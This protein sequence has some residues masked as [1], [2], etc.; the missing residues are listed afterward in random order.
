VFFSF[1]FTWFA[2]PVWADCEAYRS[3][4]GKSWVDGKCMETPLGERWWPH[5]L[6]GE[7]DQAGSTNWYTKPEIVARALAQV[8]QNRVVKI[9]QEYSSDMPLF[10][11]RQFSLRIPGG[12]T[13]DG[14][15]GNQVVWNDEFLA[16]EVGQVGT[17]FDGL[18][19]VGIQIGKAGDKNQIRFYNG[20]TGSEVQDAY[21]LKK[22]GTEHLHPIVARGVLI[23]VAAARG[24]DVMKAGEVISLADVRTALKKQGMADFELRPGDVVLFRTGWEK[25]W[26]VDNDQ[27]NAGC[28]GIGMEVARWLAEND[29]GVTGADTFAVDAVPNPDPD[30]EFCVHSY[31]QTRHGIV[32]QEN[33]TLSVLAEQGVYQFA[34]FYTPVPIRG[35]TGSI[36]S[37]AV[38]W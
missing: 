6:W 23:D 1:V 34:Y 30:C 8:K 18:G 38:M 27:Y 24:V 13:G 35:A 28:P 10:G 9:G 16:A 2:G 20:F 25:Y 19:H 14:S 32:N 3:L 29:V 17:Q 15:G 37:P 7:G 5:P 36:G 22:L 26:V 33:L 31:M 11:E 21:G 4:E 12:P